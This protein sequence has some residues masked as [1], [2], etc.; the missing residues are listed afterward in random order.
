MALP[1]MDTITTGASG[2]AGGGALGWL[3]SHLKHRETKEAIE[4][5]VHK[6]VCSSDR[7]AI[8]RRFDDFSAR[9]DRMEN[10]I[11]QL[12]AHSIRHREADVCK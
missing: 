11:D 9:Q 1:D 12:L 6:E 7:Q 4:Q 5:R 10:K 2:V 3:L 8:T